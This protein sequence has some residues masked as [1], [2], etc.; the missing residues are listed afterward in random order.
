[1]QRWLFREEQLWTVKIMLRSGKKSLSLRTQSNKSIKQL[2]F[3]CGLVLEGEENPKWSKMVFASYTG[4]KI[5]A[6]CYC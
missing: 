2:N 6:K 1:M 5:F 3:N 4:I